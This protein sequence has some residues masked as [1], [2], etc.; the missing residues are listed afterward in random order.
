[1]QKSNADTRVFGLD[2]LRAGAIGLVL[3]CHVMLMLRFCCRP[4]TGWSVMAGYFGVELFFVLSGF[5]IGGIL[6]RDF[7][8]DAN[9]GTLLRFWCRRWLRTLPLFYLFLAINLIILISLGAPK[10]DWWRHALFIQNFNGKA[11]P[12]F[13][14][15]WSLAVEEWFYLLAPLLIFVVAKAGLPVKKA[16]LTVALGGIACA[17][18][19]R[20]HVVASGSPDWLTEVRSV[21]TVRLDACM[22]GVLAAWW[23]HYSPQSWNAWSRSKLACGLLCLLGAGVMFRVL[24]LNTSFA[25]RTHLFTLTSLGTMLCLPALAAMRTP[26]GKFALG[27]TFTSKWSYAMYLVNFPI[28]TWLMRESGLGL[29]EPSTAAIAATTGLVLTVIASA[30]LHYFYETPILRWRDRRVGAHAKGVQIPAAQPA[31]ELSVAA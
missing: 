3:V 31:R 18:A 13:G 12:F 30:A 9:G 15:A 8:A 4:L 25:A 17:T 19:W 7:S 1:M 26:R 10:P 27:I 6:I 29:L 14:E 20:M 28:F 23:K 22:F 11:G 16:V 2:L 21:V 5:L 24:P